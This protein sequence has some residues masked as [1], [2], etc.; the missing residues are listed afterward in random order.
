MKPKDL[1][2][3][4]ASSM[5]FLII[6][7]NTNPAVTERV[8]LATLRCSQPGVTFE[9][10]QPKAGPYSIETPQQREQAQN[11]VLS[12]IGGCDTS[13]YAS[14][15]MACFDDLAIK[16]A[17]LISKAPVYGTCQLSVEA[18]MAITAKFSIV[19]TVPQAV[20]GIEALVR[21]HG[22]GDAFTT[23]A[24][25]IGVDQAAAAEKQTIQ[26]VVETA[27]SAIHTDGAKAILLASGGLTGYAPLLADSIGVPIIDGVEAAIQSLVKKSIYQ[28]SP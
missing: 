17:R 19:T 24:A 21:L 1:D 8:R 14:I 10:I 5:R 15:L 22:G 9:V 7:P 18:I 16:E 23:Y 27:A 2:P 11:E 12:L 3:V 6:N 28:N 4:L 25:G 20:N 26:K 13:Q